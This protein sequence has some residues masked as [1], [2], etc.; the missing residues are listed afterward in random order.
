MKVVILAGGLGTRL[1]SVVKDMPKPMADIDGRPFLE[2]LMDYMIFQ[3]ATEFVL[4]V[5][6]LKE[7]IINYFGDSFRSVPVFYS[8]E[9][10]LLGTGGAIKQAFDLYHLDKAV[11]VNG[12]T[13]VKM[14]Y[15]AFY[16]RAS[17]QMLSV[18]L[19]KIDK[20]ERFGMV[21]VKNG[22]IESFTE[23]KQGAENVFI[24]SGVYF[25]ASSLWSCVAQK[26]GVSFS[27]EK[28]VLEKIVSQIR[29]PAFRIDDYFID[30][31]VPEAYYQARKELRSVIYGA[32]A[33]FLDRDGVINVDSGYVHRIE[34]CQFITGIFD[35]CR[36]A[37]QKGYKIIVVTNQAGIAKGVYQEDEYMILRKYIHDEFIK[38]GC[39]IDAEYYCPYHID[40]IGK[41]KKDSYERKPNPGMIFQS[42]R[43][44]KVD[45]KNSILIG[46]KS[47]DIVAAQRAGIGNKIQLLGKY[48]ETP[49]AD[50]HVKS[51]CKI[52]L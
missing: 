19:K 43:D 46:D 26:S 20:A 49:M 13:F 39:S 33:L 8:I 29:V 17:E 41:Y 7:K 23:K 10:T 32:K 28:D 16:E 50:S 6:Y 21:I 11:V 25:V 3:G 12:D 42:M 37:K 15:H 51:L 34:D 5:S 4:C 44:F 52:I 9:N 27:F 18:A 48:K 2:M 22:K 45:L 30:I 35:I 1:Q 24:N 36:H 31:G 40:G 14:D 38:Q 47:E